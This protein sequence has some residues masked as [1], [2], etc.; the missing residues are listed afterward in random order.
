MSIVEIIP[1]AKII[2][3]A[4]SIQNKTA[5]KQTIEM[6]AKMGFGIKEIEEIAKKAPYERN[7]PKGLYLANSEI[8]KFTVEPVPIPKTI[9]LVSFFSI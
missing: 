6:M 3:D 7:T 9:S 8:K 2:E 5:S 1:I 4:I